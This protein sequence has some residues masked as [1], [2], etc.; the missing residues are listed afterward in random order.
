MNEK[1]FRISLRALEPED[2]LKTVK[3]RNEGIYLQGVVS[4]KRFV[5]PET[6]KR[7]IEDAIKKHESGEAV[8]LAIILKKTNEMIGMIFITNIDYI[9]KNGCVGS[10]LGSND[11][12][13][14]GYISEARYLL[15]KYAFDELGLE[16][17]YG[18]IL[19]DN[20]SARK[21]AEKFGYV[22]EGVLRNAVYKDGQFK[23]LIA[24][25]MLKKEFYEKYQLNK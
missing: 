22:K 2:Y 9:N 19:E 24:Y 21:S 7:W 23:N 3:W 15:F 14:K 17:L 16:R 13:G 11:N 5:S 6:E 4:T 12:R 10:F 1:S 25:S 18:N 8:R 20:T